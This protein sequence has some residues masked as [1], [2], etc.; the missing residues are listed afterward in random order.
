MWLESG[1]S[2]LVLQW[3]HLTLLLF[4]IVWQWRQ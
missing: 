2:S 3:T 4:N 1:S